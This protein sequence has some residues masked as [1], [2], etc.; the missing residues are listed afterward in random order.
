MSEESTFRGIALA[1]FVSVFL[2]SMYHRIR[3]HQ[4]DEKISRKE[5]DRPIMILLRL[6]H[7]SK[8]LPPQVFT[9][10]GNQLLTLPGYNGQLPFR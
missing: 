4:L 10:L 7:G 5:E 6:P 9:A 3:A 1:V 8:L 2:I